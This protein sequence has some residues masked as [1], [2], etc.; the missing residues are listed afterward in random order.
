MEMTLVKVLLEMFLALCLVGCTDSIGSSQDEVKEEYDYGV[1][2]SLQGQEAVKIAEG[3]EIVIIDAQFLSAEE[4]DE[5]KSRGQTVYSYLNIGSIEKFQSHI[6]EFQHL[7]LNP[8]K[9]WEG[10]YWVDVKA[11][12]WQEFVAVTLAKEFLE[13][14]VDGFWVDNADV[15]GQF[16]GEKIYEGVESILNTLISYGK[17]VVIN[18]G[19]EFVRTYWDRNQQL[20]DILTGVNQEMVF[21]SV[22][23]DTNSF[24]TQLADAQQYFLDY[25]DLVDE[26]GKDVF[27]LEYTVD[28]QLIRRIDGYANKNGWRYYISDSIELDG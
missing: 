26:A 19:D 28:D 21:S 24:M 10:E 23:F 27:L 20:D 25:V 7:A 12:E 1:F 13:K 15:Y 17:P 9:D 5:M 16:A 3:Y 14:G 6:K 8:Y 2:L 4:I 22:N 11:E 18:G